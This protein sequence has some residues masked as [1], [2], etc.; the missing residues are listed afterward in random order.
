MTASTRRVLLVTGGSRGIG[1]ATVRLAAQRGDA[2]AFSYFSD[3]VSAQTLVDQIESSGGQALAV[4]ADIAQEADVLRLF[5]T[6]DERFGRLDA[7]VNNAATIAPMTRLA[8]MDAAR[9]ARLFATNAVGPMLCAREAVRRMSTQRG[10]AGGAIVNISSRASRIGA[11][12]Q[13]IDY[14]ATKAAIDTLTVGLAKEVAA[15]GI[16]VNT[17][18]PGMIHTDIHAAAG[19]ADRIAKVQSAI[20][21][22]RGGEPEEIARAILWLLSDEASYVTGACLDVAGGR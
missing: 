1:A 10:G 7:L 2:V 9:I 8:D 22:Q 15:E 17:V 21:L 18:A 5:Q 20:P 4:Q 11:P 16:R 13:Y 19:D 12:G 3:A 14:A 6:V